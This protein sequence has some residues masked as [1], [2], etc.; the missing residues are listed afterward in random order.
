MKIVKRTK[1]AIKQAFSFYK[2]KLEDYRIQRE[3]PIVSQIFD[4]II[5]KKDFFYIEELSKKIKSREIKYFVK[6]LASIGYIPELKSI[7]N[8]PTVAVVIPHYNQIKYLEEKSIQA[9]KKSD[10][11]FI[12][13]F[14]L[15]PKIRILNNK[16]SKLEKNF[17]KIIDKKTRVAKNEVI[18]TKNKLDDHIKNREKIISERCSQAYKKMDSTKEVVDGLYPLIAGAIGEN[19][20][21]D[22]GDRFIL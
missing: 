15:Y 9:R 2:I 12:N 21:E 11:S 3:V 17:E 4:S 16:K 1:K 6:R 5:E 18:N 7:N 8:N 14:F 22:N 10:K 13:K 19:L 20:V